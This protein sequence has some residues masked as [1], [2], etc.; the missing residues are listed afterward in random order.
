MQ[1][2]EKEKN[3]YGICQFKIEIFV[4]QKANNQLYA[5]LHTPGFLNNRQVFKQHFSFSSSNK[6][7]ELLE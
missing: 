7:K 5:Y 4:V 6:D 3:R 1:I 2:H